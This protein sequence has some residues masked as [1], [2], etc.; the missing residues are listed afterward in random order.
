[1][2]I[3]WQHIDPDRV[4]A[5]NHE[6]LAG[7]QVADA[8]ASSVFY[9]VNRN[10]YGET[11]PRYLELLR[12]TL[13]RHKRAVVGYGIKLWPTPLEALKETLDHLTVIER[14]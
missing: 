6:Q 2:R 8:V 9:A 12:R 5:V 10:Q 1:V 14:L 7:L 11:E 13:Y 4:E 3:E